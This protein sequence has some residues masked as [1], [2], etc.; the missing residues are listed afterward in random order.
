MVR[1]RRDVVPLARAVAAFFAVQRED[2]L[3]LG[4]DPHVLGRMTMAWDRRAGRVGGE[5][6]VAA[7]AVQLERVEGPVEPGK[8]ANLLREMHRNPSIVVSADDAGHAS[9]SARRIASTCHGTAA[10]G[11][12][13]SAD[14]CGSHPAGVSAADFDARAIDVRKPRGLLVEDDRQVRYRNQGSF[15]ALAP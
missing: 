6:D 3:S 9:I 12:G 13:R 2:Q 15:P 1:P 8:I 10:A 14:R 11:W 7:L 4:D 5:Q